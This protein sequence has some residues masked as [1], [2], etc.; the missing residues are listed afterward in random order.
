MLL[1]IFQS[2]GRCPTKQTSDAKCPALIIL[3]ELG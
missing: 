2:S 1:D 3:L